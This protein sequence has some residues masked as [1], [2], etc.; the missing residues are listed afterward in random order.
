MSFNKRIY[1]INTIQHAYNNK[2]W[3]DFLSYLSAD[4]AIVQDYESGQIIEMHH[5]LTLNDLSIQSF[6]IDK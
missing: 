5:N 3:K 2:S 1:T 6:F 4:A